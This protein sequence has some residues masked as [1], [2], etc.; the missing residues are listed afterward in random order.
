[1]A[2]YEEIERNLEKFL[3]ERGFQREIRKT[4]SKSM[5]LFKLSFIIPMDDG[6]LYMV[7]NSDGN[8]EK[9]ALCYISLNAKGE[10]YLKEILRHLLNKQE[11][12]VSDIAISNFFSKE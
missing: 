9:Y 11:I 4:Y 2:S 1:M 6:D 12:S 7:L 8:E 5:G 3:T 10:N